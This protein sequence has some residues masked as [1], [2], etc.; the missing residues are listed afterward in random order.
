MGFLTVITFI[1]G[2]IVMLFWMLVGWRVRRAHEDL[3]DELR[4]IAAGFGDI[5]DL[6]EKHM[7]E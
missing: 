5:R 1:W 4:R 7:A 3:S 6:A 2:I